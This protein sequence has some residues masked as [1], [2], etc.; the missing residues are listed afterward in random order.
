MPS[1]LRVVPLLAVFLAPR[2]VAQPGA[3]GAAD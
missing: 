2:A 3:R 1:I